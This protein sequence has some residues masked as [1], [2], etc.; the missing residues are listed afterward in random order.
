MSQ[1]YTSQKTSI[2]PIFFIRQEAFLS[3]QKQLSGGEQKYLEVWDFRAN[4]GQINVLFDAAGAV[5]KVLYG[6]MEK[7]SMWE[8]AQ[9][10][11]AVPKGYTYA[12]ENI[13]DENSF[14]LSLAWGLEH[15]EFLS[16]KTDPAFKKTPRLYVPH[17]QLEALTH[18]LDVSFHVRD[19][20]NMPACDLTPAAFATIATEIAKKQGAKVHVTQGKELEKHYPLVQAVGKASVHVPQ[21]VD[22]RWGKSTHPKVTLVGKGVTF[23]TGGLDIKSASNMLWMKKDMGGA[24]QALGLAELIMRMNLPLQLRVLLPLA[25]NAISGA[26]YRP[27]D[28]IKSRKGLTVEIGDTD[29]EGRLLLADAL[30]AACEETPDYLFDFATLTGAARIAVG[31]EISAFFSNQ[32]EVGAQLIG[33]SEKTQDPIWELP[34]W[35]NY[36]KMLHSSVAD[37]NSCSSGGYAGAT[38]A[39]LFLKKFVSGNIPW[40]HFDLMAW[41]V[42]SKPGRP[43][44]GEVMALRAVYEFLVTVST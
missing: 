24:A 34:L 19:W 10:A 14:L 18:F 35:D 6:A 7:R 44:G 23:D 42:S 26:A 5:S 12:F 31:T 30:T 22:I 41:N 38:T 40:V 11:R 39:A 29:A 4:P 13:E 15:Y 32:K 43:E 3:F 28:V 25:E 37:T 33:A 2:I 20:I 1:V 27:S 17:N 9:L 8:G 21:V 36:E 16:Y